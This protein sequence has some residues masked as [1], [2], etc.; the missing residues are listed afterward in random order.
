M[1]RR[2]KPAKKALGLVQPKML[3]SNSSKF[4]SALSRLGSRKKTAPRGFDDFAA[5]C[6]VEEEKVVVNKTVSGRK[7]RHPSLKT[8]RRSASFNSKM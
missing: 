8:L 7:L 2:T 4:H 6:E 1:K 3:H 5:Q